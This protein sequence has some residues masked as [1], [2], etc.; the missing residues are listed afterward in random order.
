M[1]KS[2]KA[3]HGL[4]TAAIFILLEIAAIGMLK[5][6]S[7]LQDIWINR[8]SH[9][10]MAALWG[11]GERIR[12]HFSLEKQ[13]AALEL[14][15]HELREQVRLYQAMKELKVEAGQESAFKARDFKYIPA[16]VT[17]IS[18]NTAH[19]YIIVNKGSADGIKPYSGII[20][21]KGVV[22]IIS[23]VDK[24]YSY[25][26]TIMNSNLSV[27]SRIGKSGI[28]SPLI[29]D[30]MHPDRATLKDVPPHYVVE[31]GDTVLTSGFSSIFPPDIPIGTTGKSSL[32]DG[33][34][35]HTEV[36]LFENLSALRYVTIVENPSR[37]EIFQLENEM[38]D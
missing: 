17:K 5:R 32:V 8:F 6:S 16:T 26:M 31:P 22:G 11:G 29:W 2:A 24:H 23:A 28:V 4:M 21:S 3:Y 27:S 30:G 1:P 35:K 12:N 33:V 15:N 25:G 9:R 7:T 38:G 19:N 20:T 10:T 36:F 37:S 34:A 18:R 13:N 14:E